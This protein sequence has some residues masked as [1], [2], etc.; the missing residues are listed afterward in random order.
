MSPTIRTL[1]ERREERQDSGPATRD[2]ARSSPLGAV[3]QLRDN[4]YAGAIAAGLT[5]LGLTACIFLPLTARLSTAV[6]GD[7]TDPWQT[8]WGF[9]Y[10][11]NALTEGHSIMWS[12]LVWWPLGAPLWLQ[13]WDIP[14]TLLA[15]TVWDDGSGP[16]IYNALLLATFPLSG[17]AVFLLCRLLWTGWLGSFGAGLVYSFSS[18][19]YANA[20]GVLHTSS[21]EWLPLFVFALFRSGASRHSSI[22]AV[23]A[24]G[25]AAMATLA[26]PYH[27]GNCALFVIALIAW[28]LACG[29]PLSEN[30]PAMRNVALATIAFTSLAGWYLYGVAHTYVTWPLEGSHEPD[31]FSV[32]IQSLFLP[33]PISVWASSISA[34][35]AWTASHWLGAPRYWAGAGHI[36]VVATLLAVWGMVVEKRARAFLAVSAVALVFALGPYLQYAG[37]LVAGPLP[38]AWLAHVIP[39][40]TLGGTPSR[41]ME[42]TMLGVAVGTGAALS[43][44]VAARPH[45]RILSVCLMAL[46]VAEAWPTQ[47]PMSEYPR[48]PIFATWRQDTAKWAV[49]DTTWW[50]QALYGQTQHGHP[51]VSAYLTRTPKARMDAIRHSRELGPLLARLIPDSDVKQIENTAG[52]IALLQHMNVRFIIAVEET[53]SL[54]DTLHLEVAYRGYGLVIYKVP[55]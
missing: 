12:T 28:R 53:A 48:P 13:S 33:N 37:R 52:T 20:T 50:G 32:D 6:I 3:G 40:L 54:F 5:Y 19:H 27:A 44:L 9:W 1:A 25:S 39:A 55:T 16:A 38:Y 45:G 29:E 17:L 49:L 26:S 21:M 35:S 24:G 43:H 31:K 51:L 4:P 10:W 15:I 47:L 42:L 11:H 41:F 30:L 34:S 46:L 7:K 23:A 2:Y 36:G 22:W 18:Y 8:L 14:S